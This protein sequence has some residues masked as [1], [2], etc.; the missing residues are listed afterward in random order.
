MIDM[1]LRVG[2]YRLTFFIRN[3][4]LPLP[5]VVFCQLLSWRCYQRLQQEKENMIT[6]IE[7]GKKTIKKSSPGFNRNFK[8]V[9]VLTDLNILGSFWENLLPNVCVL[10]P[11]RPQVY[12]N[13]LKLLLRWTL[14]P[15]S[16][17][18]CPFLHFLLHE[19]EKWSFL[20]FL[21]MWM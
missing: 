2:T 20:S 10:L 4:S 14:K 6:E 19:E 17:E 1:P 7:T 18:L 12:V 5:C 11:I 21:E 16:G 15:R 3:R 8:N 13:T 9:F